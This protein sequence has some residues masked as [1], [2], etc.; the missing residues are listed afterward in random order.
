MG[1]AEGYNNAMDNIGGRI[2]GYIVPPTTGT[3][4]FWVASD[5][6]SEFWGSG[7]ANPANKTL[8]A[9]VAG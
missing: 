5:D 3:Y 6:Y 8:L 7:D 4:Y 9:S 1:I 2:S